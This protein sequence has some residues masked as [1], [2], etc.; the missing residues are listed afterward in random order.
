MSYSAFCQAF[1]F[2]KFANYFDAER[3]DNKGS[4]QISQK[5]YWHGWFHWQ[6]SFLVSVIEKNKV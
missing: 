6:L 1:D 3:W 2:E 5:I 4:C